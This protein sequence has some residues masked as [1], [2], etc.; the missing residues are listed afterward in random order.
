[1]IISAEIIGLLMWII[2]VCVF[3]ALE[4]SHQQFLLFTLDIFEDQT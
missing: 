2:S 4:T 3:Y 1:M